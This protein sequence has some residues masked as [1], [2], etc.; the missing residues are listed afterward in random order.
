[1]F[2]KTPVP[3]RSRRSSSNEGGMKGFEKQLGTH[4]FGVKEILFSSERKQQVT[5]LVEDADGALY[6][7]KWR[8]PEHDRDGERLDEE[9]AI[10]RD[11]PYPA[12]MPK[13]VVS[14]PGLLVVEY[15]ASTTLREFLLARQPGADRE[16]G[17]DVAVVNRLFDFFDQGYGFSSFYLSRQTF[18]HLMRY[19]WK[20]TS[21]GP[22]GTRKRPMER[23]FNR[24]LVSLPVFLM[25]LFPINAPSVEQVPTRIHGDLHLNNILVDSTR[26]EITIIDW[27]TTLSESP[28]LDF[29]YCTA[30][31]GALLD[32]GPGKD[33]FETSVERSLSAM[34]VELRPFAKFFFGLFGAII[35]TNS[36]FHRSPAPL[37]RAR[38]WCTAYRKVFFGYPGLAARKR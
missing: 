6:V 34:D 14:E 20:L 32:D 21:S 27:E 16:D 35:A 15:V 9:I 4:G 37:R 29:L 28:L 2:R 19:L 30:M 23:F 22:A 11:G 1:M 8:S 17:V 33:A 12:F 13:S 5:A 25:K 36:R 26:R 24:F 10:Y 38:A 18:D 7:A 3:K 31:L